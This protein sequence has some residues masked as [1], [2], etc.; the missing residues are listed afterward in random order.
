MHLSRGTGRASQKLKSGIFFF[1]GLH[2]QPPMIFGKTWSGWSSEF[3]S[4]ISWLFSTFYLFP[5]P[6]DIDF[7]ENPSQGFGKRTFPGQGLTDVSKR[8]NGSFRHRT[9]HSRVGLEMRII[10]EEEINDPEP[11]SMIQGDSLDQK[12]WG[13]RQKKGAKGPLLS[14]ES[15]RLVLHVVDDFRSELGTLDLGGSFELTGEV[16]G[17]LLLDN[18][19]FHAL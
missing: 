18:R 11:L 6:Q 1:T 14:L 16:I 12:N 8:D 19:V 9:P 15:K 5:V 3:S 17:D 4:C 13:S 2:G 7:H 10:L